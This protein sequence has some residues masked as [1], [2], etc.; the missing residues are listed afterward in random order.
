MKHSIIKYIFLKMS[1]LD[2]FTFIKLSQCVSIKIAKYFYT[3]NSTGYNYK[4][5]KG[6]R[7]GVICGQN[8]SGSD[9]KSEYLVLIF[10]DSRKIFPCENFTFKS[11]SKLR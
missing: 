2:L 3:I 5:Y 1:L 6:I 4:E 9:F 11:A 8:K 10:M 7:V